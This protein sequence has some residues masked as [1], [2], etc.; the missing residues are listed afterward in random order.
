MFGLDRDAPELARFVTGE[1]QDPP[2]P[3]RVA[4]EHLLQ[5]VHF[6]PEQLSRMTD[7]QLDR[8]EAAYTVIVA[9][10]QEVAAAEAQR[11]SFGAR[12]TEHT[13]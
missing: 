6:T 1:K 7:E 11:A 2:C 12:P 9:L 13:S 4:L 5:H 3:F 8:L 10:E